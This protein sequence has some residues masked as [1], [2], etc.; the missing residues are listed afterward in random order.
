MPVFSIITIGNSIVLCK[1]VELMSDQNNNHINRIYSFDFIRAVCALGIVVFHYSCQIGDKLYR[2]LF[3]FANGGWGEVF[4]GAFFLLSGAMLYYN[5]SEIKNLKAFY[6]KRFKSIFP[7][8]YIAF[9][10][11]FIWS[12]I[13]TKNF[14]MAGTL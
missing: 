5:H 11:F 12:V 7:M 6:F 13:S 4:V 10:G 9:L 14:F 8:F 1:R 3:S 2:P